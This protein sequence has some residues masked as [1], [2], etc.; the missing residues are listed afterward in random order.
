MDAYVERELGGYGELDVNG[1]LV[2]TSMPVAS[3]TEAQMA[4]LVLMVNWLLMVSLF[5][6]LG[7]VMLAVMVATI[8]IT[9]FPLLLFFL[10]FILV[11]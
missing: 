9:F 4:G 1:E 11:D 8:K 6:C 10:G 5:G 7:W 3:L 2:P